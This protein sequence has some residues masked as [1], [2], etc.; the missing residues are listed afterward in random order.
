MTI[1]KFVGS[2]VQNVDKICM[3]YVYLLR[4][5]EFGNA[6]KEYSNYI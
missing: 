5:N 2:I 1:F 4:R 3:R 6:E